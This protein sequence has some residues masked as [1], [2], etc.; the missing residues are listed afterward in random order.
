MLRLD[1]LNESMNFARFC[2]FCLLQMCLNTRTLK[3]EFPQSI[4]FVRCPWV[5]TS[6]YHYHSW[7]LSSLK[8]ET[9]RVEKREK[10]NEKRKH[11]HQLEWLKVF[12]SF[13]FK[14]VSI[15]LFIHC[16]AAFVCFSNVWSYVPWACISSFLKLA[17]TWGGRKR[18]REGSN[19]SRERWNGQ[20]EGKQDR[21][22]NISHILC[23][24]MLYR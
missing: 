13:M 18:D 3:E 23:N 6:C 2:A 15:F 1:C 8:W 21:W 20:K 4:Y 24:N 14:Y 11:K 16:L 19:R 10:T 17:N 12:I 9:G 22:Y 7:V 5:N